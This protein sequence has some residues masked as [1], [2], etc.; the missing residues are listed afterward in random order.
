M[1]EMGSKNG[2]CIIILIW[3]RYG[4]LLFLSYYY[5]ELFLD[6]LFLQWCQHVCNGGKLPFRSPR[7]GTKKRQKL[8]EQITAG[9]TENHEN[10]MSHLSQ[11]KISSLINFH[12]SSVIL[13]VPEEDPGGLFGSNSE[14]LCYTLYYW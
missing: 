14:R 4:I 11:G 2:L 6:R 9:I 12:H 10:E 5:T 3:Y 8:L 1:Y 13:Y 7:Q